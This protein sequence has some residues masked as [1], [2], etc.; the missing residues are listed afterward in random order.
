MDFGSVSDQDMTCLLYCSGRFGGA[1]LEA[2]AVVSSL[3]EVEAVGQ[4]TAHSTE[5]RVTWI[6]SQ[7][8]L[9]RYPVYFWA[10]INRQ[11]EYPQWLI[12]CQKKPMKTSP[13][14]AQAA[15]AVSR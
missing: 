15:S 12:H 7:W 6:K 9:C 4:V 3:Q 2:E 13:N 10:E 8:K 5:Q 11:A 1:G 14:A